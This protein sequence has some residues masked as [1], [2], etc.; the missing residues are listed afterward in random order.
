MTPE[1]IQKEFH[2]E[3][4]LLL[5]KYNAEIT[6]EDFGHDYSRDEKIVVDFGFYESLF[7]EHNTGIIPKL[8][9]GTY[10]C[11]D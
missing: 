11:G 4:K 8:V 2:K 5:K 3:L 10:E 9:L 6:L 1:N 7:E